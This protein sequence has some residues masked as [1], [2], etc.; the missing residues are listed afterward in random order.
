MRKNNMEPL[1]KNEIA[2][3][4]AKQDELAGQ[5]QAQ[6]AEQEQE[7]WKA[8]QQR[9]AEAEAQANSGPEGF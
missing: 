3:E 2:E 1:T 7:E 4:K 8:Q 5:A 6:Q 9:E